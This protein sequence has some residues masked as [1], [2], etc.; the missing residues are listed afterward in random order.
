MHWGSVLKGY[1]D[2]DY[3]SP[4]GLY[5]QAIPAFSE[6][7]FPQCVCVFVHVGKSGAQ[8]HGRYALAHLN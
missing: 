8:A 2:L 1:G 3:R 7:S 5:N 4:H 6:D